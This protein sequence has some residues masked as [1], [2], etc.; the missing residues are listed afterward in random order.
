[1]EQR[2][3]RKLIRFDDRTAWRTCSD[4][5]HCNCSLLSAVSTT[6]SFCCFTDF[7]TSFFSTMRL[8]QSTQVS[9][10]MDLRNR[11]ERHHC[12]MVPPRQVIESQQQEGGDL[13]KPW[14]LR[15]P[16]LAS[17]QHKALHQELLFCHRRGLLPRKRPE[18]QC[19]LENKRR[20]QLKRRELDLLPPS[21]LEVKL[22]RIQHRIQAYE[23]E[24]KKRS[25]SLRNLPE[26]V[27]VR[28]NLKHIQ[29][30]FL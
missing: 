14:R 1:M 5:P 30:C 12:W 2:D 27:R 25:E 15:N 19:V 8:Y 29:T 23:L 17:P 7:S 26:F 18:L 4:Q 9:Q 6:Q 16:V 22:R 20:E 3:V 24:E 21:D 13:I 10:K 28:G 11:R